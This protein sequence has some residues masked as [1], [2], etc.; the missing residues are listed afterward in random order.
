MNSSTI[1][2]AVRRADVLFAEHADEREDGE[3]HERRGGERQRFEDPPDGAEHRDGGGPALGGV[4]MPSWCIAA[5]VDG[6][7]HEA[8]EGRPD[9]AMEHRASVSRSVWPSD[10]R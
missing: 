5:K 10:R 8:G 4:G 2:I 7:E 9:S 1:G 6:G 3:R